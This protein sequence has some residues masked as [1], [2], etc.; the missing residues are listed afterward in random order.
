MLRIT[1]KA[2][3]L[4]FALTSAGWTQTMVDGSDARAVLDVARAYGSAALETLSNGDPNI[5]G[6]I[7]GIGYAVHF[8]NCTD[9]STCGSLN[10]YTAFAD[11]KP[12]L[13][14]IN[15]W[16][17]GKRYGR[18][19]LDSDLDAA[20]E[21]DVNLSFG[22]SR[23]NLDSNFSIWRLVLTQFMDHIGLARPAP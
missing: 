12:T 4:W 6:R 5:I 22:V 17:N 18:A 1:L 8:L 16:N 7:D 13:E 9:N 14:Q 11:V 20:V 23:A 3:F 15:A 10:F 21:M 19:Y 2:A